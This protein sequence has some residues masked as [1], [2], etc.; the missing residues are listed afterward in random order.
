MFAYLG[1]IAVTFVEPWLAMVPFLA[2]AVMWL[3]PDRR[4]ERYLEQERSA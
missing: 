1:A 2:V 3:V 4:I